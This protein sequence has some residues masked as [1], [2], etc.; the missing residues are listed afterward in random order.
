MSEWLTLKRGDDTIG[1]VLIVGCDN[2]HILGRFRAGPDYSSYEELLETAYREFDQETGE[3]LDVLEEVNNLGLRLESPTGDWAKNIR[4]FQP[5]GLECL[6]EKDGVPVEF[7][8][9]GA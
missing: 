3:W 2:W 8:F 1:Y 7:K 4:D 9:F 6:R 5:E